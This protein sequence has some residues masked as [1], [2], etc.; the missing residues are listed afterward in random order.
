MSSAESR[1]SSYSA[2]I[3]LV[4]RWTDARLTP[5]SL[6]TA[7][8]TWAE[9]AEQV[10]PVTTNLVF[11]IYSSD[12]PRGCGAY[13]CTLSSGFVKRGSAF[14]RRDGQNL[15]AKS[16]PEGAPM[17]FVLMTDGDAIN[18]VLHPVR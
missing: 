16:A 18:T 6:L 8:S 3:E 11:V 2:V 1:L 10:M 12:T 4:S 15:Q 14:L 13:H 9:H 5:A 7:F 17:R